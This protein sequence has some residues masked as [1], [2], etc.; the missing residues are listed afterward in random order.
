[1]GLSYWMRNVIAKIL[2]RYY[3]GLPA[4]LLA[5]ALNYFNIAVEGISVGP[6][7]IAAAVILWAW[8]VWPIVAVTFVILGAIAP[9][10]CKLGGSNMKSS[11]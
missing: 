7:A 10:L 11:S 9:A 8:P 1:M 2:A 5:L 4:L 6:W 3:I